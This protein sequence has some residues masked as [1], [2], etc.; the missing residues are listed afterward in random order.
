MNINKLHHKKD[1]NGKK[2][3]AKHDSDK[4]TKKIGNRNTKHLSFS[5]A[6]SI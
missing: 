1:K 3:V 5:T 2:V 6:L 4:V